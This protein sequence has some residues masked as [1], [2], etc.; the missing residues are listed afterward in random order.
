MS[1]LV[2][3]GLRRNLAKWIADTPVSCSIGTDKRTLGAIR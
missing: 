2:T 1:L 3:Q